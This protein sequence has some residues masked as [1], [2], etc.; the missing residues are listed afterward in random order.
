MPEEWANAFEP[1]MALWGCTGIPVRW[2]T[3]RLITEYLS[4][5]FVS[6]FVFNK[7]KFYAAYANWPDNYR[8]YVVETIRKTY[9]PDKKGLR[10]RLYG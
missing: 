10:E 4:F 1:T 7:Q 3:N 8:K 9:L 2:L 5:D 6:L